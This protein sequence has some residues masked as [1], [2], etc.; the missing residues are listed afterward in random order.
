MHVICKGAPS[1]CN[2]ALPCCVPPTISH[3]MIPAKLKE[4]K[5]AFQNDCAGL[6][7]QIF[8]SSASVCSMSYILLNEDLKVPKHEILG[9]GFVLSW[10]MIFLSSY[11]L[12]E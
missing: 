7:L 5:Y 10:S 6:H 12:A 4:I 8:T 3:D 11:A 2:H 1:P 9:R